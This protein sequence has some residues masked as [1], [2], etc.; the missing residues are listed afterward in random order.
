MLRDERMAKNEEKRRETLEAMK[1]LRAD[2]E[3]VSEYRIMRAMKIPA[4]GGGYS[5][6]ECRFIAEVLGDLQ[7]EGNIVNC[8]PRCWMLATPHPAQPS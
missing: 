5:E 7:S 4:K 2:S 1:N 6:E 8:P 3:P